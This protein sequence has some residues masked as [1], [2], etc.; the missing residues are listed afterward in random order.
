MS[1]CMSIPAEAGGVYVRPVQGNLSPDLA[2]LAASVD[3]DPP[4]P[5]LP[6]AHLFGVMSW[7]EREIMHRQPWQISTVRCYCACQLTL[8]TS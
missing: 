2:N 6:G 3:S 5:L 8:N 4:T 1:I 7:A